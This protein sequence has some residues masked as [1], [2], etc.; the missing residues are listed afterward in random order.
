[1][2]VAPWLFTASL[3]ITTPALSV[4]PKTSASGGIGSSTSA[5]SAGEPAGGTYSINGTTGAAT[6]SS[7]IQT[8]NQSANS[9]YAAPSVSNGPPTFRALTQIDLPIGTGRIAT[10][11]VVLTALPSSYGNVTR[12]GYYTSG[13]AP[14]LAYTASTSA[15]S[16]NSGAGDGGSQI[17]TSD[18]KCWIA[19]FPAVGPDIRQFGAKGD[20]STS[21]TAAVQNWVTYLYTNSRVGTVSTGQ[22]K[23]TAPIT[24]P[25]ANFW[26]WKGVGKYKSAFFYA[27]ASTTANIFDFGG[28]ST[29]SRGVTFSDFTVFS[30]VTMTG[31][32]TF[33]LT[34]FT[35]PAIDDVTFGGELYAK[36]TWHGV[37]FNGVHE[38]KL[39]RFDIMGLGDGIIVNAGNLGNSSNSDLYLNTGF[40]NLNGGAGIRQAGGFGGLNIDQ[41]QLLGN[42]AGQLIVDNSISTASNRETILGTNF[43]ADGVLSTQDNIVLNS[44]NSSSANLISTGT[45]GSGTRY[46]I[47]V[48]SWP[49]GYVNIAAGR[50]FNNQSD[51]VHM[52]D[53]TVTLI[54][55]STSIDTNG[56]LGIYSSVANA[57]AYLTCPLL[58]NTA[59]GIATTL[60]GWKSTFTPV[61]TAG[62]GTFTTA[63]ASMRYNVIGKTVNFRAIINITTNG[64]AA[65]NATITLPV[66]AANPMVVTGRANTSGKAL[67]GYI[68][69]STLNILNY[70]NSYPGAN[71]ESMIVSGTYEAQ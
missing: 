43:V 65:G 8:S 71:G 38:G 6:F 2:R 24:A 52:T 22:Y 9:I 31:G 17:P 59:G 46:G 61:L 54:C 21:D 14:A 67:Q 50:I 18:G 35:D 26:G 12:T 40:S 23:L 57:N 5:Y 19:S 13:D 10:T 1:M 37:W 4:G 60:G 68:S 55:G 39:T 34:N 49:S 47:N 11:N 25:A 45:I 32:T 16:L 42:V 51:G 69:V 3:L 41:V 53:G 7:V 58:N 33:K 27:G 29:D 15:C 28:T 48:I 62:S 70:D 20:G 30:F 56:G 44:P 64:T 63:S 36:N 66:A